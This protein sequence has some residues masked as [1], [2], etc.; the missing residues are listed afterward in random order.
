VR[1]CRFDG[2]SGKEVY[3]ASRAPLSARARLCEKEDY[4]K[5]DRVVAASVIDNQRFGAGIG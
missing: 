2:L 5:C 1:G 4:R 3:R